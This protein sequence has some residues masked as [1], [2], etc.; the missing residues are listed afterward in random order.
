MVIFPIIAAVLF[1]GIIFSAHTE[2]KK[3]TALGNESGTRQFSYFS[4]TRLNLR[5][6]SKTVRLISFNG[7]G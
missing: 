6:F 4:M 3:S 7:N 5:A 1:L 2:G